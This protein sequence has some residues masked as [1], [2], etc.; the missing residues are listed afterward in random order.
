[1]KF[2]RAV[3]GKNYARRKNQAVG[4]QNEVANLQGLSLAQPAG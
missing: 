3:P 1:M 2:M 4:S